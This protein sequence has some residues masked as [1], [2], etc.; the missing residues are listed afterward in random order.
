MTLNRNEFLQPK[1]VKGS[2]Q[3][4]CSGGVV[5]LAHIGKI[6]IINTF[7][8]RLKRVYAD[9]IPHIRSMLFET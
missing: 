8:E 1:P 5:A 4:S 2:N 9:Q 3:P 7:E 6:R